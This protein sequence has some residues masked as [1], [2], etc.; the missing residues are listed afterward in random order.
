MKN[1]RMLPLTPQ[2]R[3][4][5]IFLMCV[6]LVG[7]GL[8]AYARSHVDR[9]VEEIS[10]CQARMDLNTAGCDDLVRTRAVT[11]RM[12]ERIIAYRNEQGAFRDIEE[13]KGVKGISKYRYERLRDLCFVEEK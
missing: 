2:E 13:I 12:A 3:T 9:A 6:W 10:R 1:F 7:L 8:N 11:K 4:A 5:A